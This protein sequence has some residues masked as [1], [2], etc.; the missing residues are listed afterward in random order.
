MRSAIC[1]LT[2][3][4]LASSVCWAQGAEKKIVVSGTDTAAVFCPIALPFDGPAP[5]TSV[6]V[7]DTATG[8][9]HGATVRDGELVFVADELK[10]NQDATFRVETKNVLD[11][12]QVQ[13]EPAGDAK[14]DVRVKG[15][16]FTSYVYSNDNRKPF[17][18]PVYCE[19][20]ETITRNWPMGTDTYESNDHIHHKSIWASYGDLNG[21]D[22]WGEGENSGYQHSDEVTYGSG[23]AYGWIHAKNTWQDKDH[24]PVIAEEREYRFYNTPAGQRTFDFKLTFTAAY[25]PVTF[26]GTKEGGILAYRIRPEIQANYN[27]KKTKTVM[28]KGTMTNAAGNP[29]NEIWGKKSPWTDYSGDIEGIGVR[30]IAA[31]DHPGNLRHPTNWHIRDYGLNGANVFGLADFTNGQE[32]GDYVLADGQSLVFNYRVIIHSGDVN[33]AKV[34]ERYSDYAKPPKA[35][36]AK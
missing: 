21:V 15:E 11:V 20:G 12:P 22:C 8:T 14:L 32:N 9:A 25:G 35:E 1:V 23:D 19:G 27:N 28:H 10:P 16:P 17:L 4:V 3:V 29:M 31:F 24:K 26:K 34:A 13:I 30:G 6:V 36:W 2:L 5:E 33:E 18:W 7:A